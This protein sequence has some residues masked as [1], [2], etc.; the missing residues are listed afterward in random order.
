MKY[1]SKRAPRLWIPRDWRPLCAL[2][3]REQ[4]SSRELEPSPSNREAR[5][6]SEIF[7]N[8]KDLE[9][10]VLLPPAGGRSCISQDFLSLDAR[11]LR[12]MRLRLLRLGGQ[13][14]G[15]D[16][17]L[18][19]Y[20]QDTPT[21]VN[22][23]GSDP[24]DALL[25]RDGELGLKARP[26]HL[27]KKPARATPIGHLKEAPHSRLRVAVPADVDRRA[28]LPLQRGHRGLLIRQASPVEP[29]SP[30][31]LH[32]DPQVATVHIRVEHD[33]AVLRI[34]GHGTLRAPVDHHV[35]RSRDHL[36]R[37]LALGQQLVALRRVVAVD[38]L[39]GP[40][41][42][43][44]PQDLAAAL[45]SSVHLAARAVLGAVRGV[46]VQADDL[47]AIAGVLL[48]PAGV[49]LEAELGVLAHGEGGL[50]AVQ[51]PDDLARGPVDLVHG[52]G[53]ARRDEVVAG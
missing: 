24:S 17:N 48:Q 9:D 37:P 40:L 29:E 19:R 46:V 38:E 15:L 53:V 4:S 43:V 30:V 18:L 2:R 41:V 52:A 1:L 23:L 10:G 21:L 44:D 7:R 12:A 16:A 27:P 3:I 49:V 5:L 51:P 31:V 33:L 34:L 6:R 11:L 42:G 36:R 50:L 25:V 26:L 13:H 28:V 22:R 8:A 39:G 47:N 20:P 45:L 32:A 35:P 14:L